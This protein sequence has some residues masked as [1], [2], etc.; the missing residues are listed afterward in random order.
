MMGLT[1]LSTE[2]MLLISGILFVII[3]VTIVATTDKDGENY[4]HTFSSLPAFVIVLR[5]TLEATVLLA[6]L[7]QYLTRAG[8]EAVRDKGAEMEEKFKAYKSQVWWGAALGG[9]G[10]TIFGAV[11]LTLYYTA[12]QLMPP[13]VAYIVEGVLLGFAC[14]ELTYFFVTHLA[15]GMK[16]DN[17]WKKKWE[18]NLTG[19]ID[20]VIK[21]GDK[22]KFF[23]LTASTVFREGFEAVV[24]ITPF[25]P[26]APPWALTLAGILGLVVG[27][28]LGITTF[29]GSQKMD[30]TK[31]FIAAS[32]FFLFMS[33]GLAGHASY[34]F[35][36]AGVFGT[37]A[38]DYYNGTT[39]TLD[40][41]GDHAD[42]QEIDG[43]RRYLADSFDGSTGFV[44]YLTE[45]LDDDCNNR[46]KS[47]DDDFFAYRRLSS[48]SSDDDEFYVRSK[49][50]A[51]HSNLEVAWVNQEV[52]DISGCCDIGFE[53][54]GVFFFI[55][56]IL[57]WYRP[58]MSRLELMM[59]CLYWPI[60]LSWGYW[61]IRSIKESNKKL[62]EDG[63][64]QMTTMEEY[65]VTFTA[66]K[67]GLD[68]GD[69]EGNVLVKSCDDMCEHSKTIGNGDLIY[70]VNGQT[71]SSLKISTYPGLV[72]HLLGK[73]TERPLTMTLKRPTSGL[74]LAHAT[75]VADE[76]EAA[77]IPEGALVPRE[78]QETSFFSGIF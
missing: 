7:I 20:E 71:L 46:V 78:K 5:E 32:V 22:R 43:Y 6:V 68:L 1:S 39:V 29:M 35:Q 38:C 60:A 49:S 53:G 9:L 61:K 33:A 58:M 51:C 25:A 15:P 18:V 37:W 70:A 17:Q 47:E 45:E 76:S 21:G 28:V 55:L 30:L 12:D 56:M 67:L 10:T 50:C 14:I 66:A 4:E 42:G 77:D 74:P 19:M 3:V 44:R 26:L 72:K 13:K 31:F 65:D 23:W 24:F 2:M 69:G 59:M 62:N 41:G 73:C 36:K 63:D 52:W 16:N 11:I 54:S 8:E 40:A 64:V 34:E 75:V 57:F 27:L 48:P